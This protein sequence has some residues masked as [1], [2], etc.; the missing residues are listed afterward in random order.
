[1]RQDDRASWF[2]WGGG[3]VENSGEVAPLELSGEG[4]RKGGGQR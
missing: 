3:V 1:M 2:F 4:N